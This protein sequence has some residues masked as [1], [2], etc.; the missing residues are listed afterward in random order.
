MTFY[1][2]NEISKIQ[3]PIILRIGEE[4]LQFENGLVLSKEQFDKRYTV[5]SVS[6]DDNRIVICLEEGVMFPVPEGIKHTEYS[7]AD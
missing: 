6:A 5:S 7:I 1:L 4:E 2:D 3:S